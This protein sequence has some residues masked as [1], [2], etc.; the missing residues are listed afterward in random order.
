VFKAERSGSDD[1]FLEPSLLWKQQLNVTASRS[2]LL[3]ADVT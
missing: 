2:A 3:S 1:G